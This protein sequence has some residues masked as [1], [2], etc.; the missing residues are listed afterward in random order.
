MST[1]FSFPSI[2]NVRHEIADKYTA[3]VT[4]GGNSYKMSC[5]LRDD[6]SLEK[7][8]NVFKENLRQVVHMYDSSM[9][10]M[11]F[12][13]EHGVK[14]KVKFSY[15]EVKSRF[16]I[17]MDKPVS[18]PVFLISAFLSCAAAMGIV[19]LSESRYR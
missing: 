10:E 19:A 9:R 3:D 11:K 15:R 4:Y 14:L 16:S 1:Y 6:H 8:D 5:K 12:K 2:T 18:M 17:D 7:A 13:P